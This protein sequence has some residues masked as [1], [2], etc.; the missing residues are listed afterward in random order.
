VFGG[1][2]SV[3]TLRLQLAYSSVPI[4]PGQK[5][6]YFPSI[7]LCMVSMQR[8][9][10]VTSGHDADERLI[11]EYV[12][13]SLDRLNS[14]DGCDGV[15][16][17]RFGMDPR[18][19]QSEIKLGIYGDYEAVIESE[20]DRWDELESDGAIESWSRDGVPFTDHPD[21]VQEFLGRLY[22]LAS[23]MSVQHFQEF[24]ERPGLVDAFP[25][26]DLRRP[27]G[28]WIVF[29]LL[30]NQAGYNAEE[31]IEAYTLAIRDRLSALT[32]THGYEDARIIVDDLR[33]EL[34][35]IEERIDELEERGGFDYYSGPD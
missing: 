11:R 2:A 5:T 31:E 30:A 19:E 23:R 14:I 7:S 21:E 24:G 22:V 9:S 17:S 27:V 6:Y 15:R 10:M 26:E 13:P 33:D 4:H 12:V 32:E 28:W 3:S 34:T 16:F 8:V 18:W 35:D 20:R 29:H 25:D 1:A